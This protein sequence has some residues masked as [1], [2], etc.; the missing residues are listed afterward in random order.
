MQPLTSTESSGVSS[1]SPGDCLENNSKWSYQQVLIQWVQ[2]RTLK[3]VFSRVSL[4]IS[5][6]TQNW[7][8][9]FNSNIFDM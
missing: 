7:K 2:V 6:N 8:L 3:S 5:I 1:E 4:L 9:P